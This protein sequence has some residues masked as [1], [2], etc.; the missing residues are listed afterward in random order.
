[1]PRTEPW[2]NYS[3]AVYAYRAPRRLKGIEMAAA[4]LFP[5][6]V[7]VKPLKAEEICFR[8]SRFK[9]SFHETTQPGN[10]IS[11]DQ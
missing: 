5:G 8:I 4:M 11:R 1:M 7:A 9:F 2:A 3:V 6:G 10:T